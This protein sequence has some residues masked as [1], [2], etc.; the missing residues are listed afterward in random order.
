MEN[1]HS[2]KNEKIL[3]LINARALDLDS[4]EEPDAWTRVSTAFVGERF[5]LKDSSEFSAKFTVSMPDACINKNLTNN[6]LDAREAGGDG[7]AFV[8][9][10]DSTI[11]GS[12]HTGMG[13]YGIKDSLAIELDSHFNGAYCNLETPGGAYVNW[14]Y[15][16][17]IFTNKS[18]DY[19]QA[20]ADDTRNHGLEYDW[21]SSYWTY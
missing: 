12:I 19:L 15:D 21:N 13:Y 9:T 11:R 14:A 10:P 4:A 1:E 17:Q 16:N 20:V 18:F 5:S 3:R 6:G 8:M 7:I 2:G